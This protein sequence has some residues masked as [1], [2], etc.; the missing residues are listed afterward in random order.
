[1]SGIAPVP[2]EMR[3]EA[4]TC[5]EIQRQSGDLKTGRHG[6]AAFGQLC[7]DL[8]VEPNIHFR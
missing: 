1:V 6:A 2:I 8:L 4:A 5:K 3:S 7:H